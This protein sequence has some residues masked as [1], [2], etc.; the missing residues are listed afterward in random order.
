MFEKLFKK[1][2]AMD[3]N[4]YAP[5]EGEYIELEKI[6]DKVFASGMIGTG[7]GIVPKG[8]KVTAP[9]NGEIIMVA[10]TK[11]AIGIKSEMGAE[12]LL[13]I[14]LETV[15]MNGEGFE[16]LVKVGDKIKVGQD[17]LRFDLKKI[18]EKADSEIS[19]FLISNSDEFEKI[20]INVEKNYE[21]KRKNRGMHNKI[22][23]YTLIKF[24]KKYKRSIR[25]NVNT[26]FFE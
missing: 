12:I 22:N 25:R 4:L 14:G 8:E 7:C 2:E 17:L 23:M 19:A 20:N 9:V 26:F 6:P 1:K 21:K 16:V 15:A 11:H 13:H 5:I 24:I 3:N 10:D 18:E